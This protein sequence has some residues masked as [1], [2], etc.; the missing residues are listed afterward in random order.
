MGTVTPFET[1]AGR[2][3]RVR[4]RTP[5]RRQT[6]K[7]GFKTK[8]DAEFFLANVEV[9]K[10]SGSFVRPS[11]VAQ[12][13][14][15]LGQVSAVSSLRPAWTSDDSR[16]RSATVVLRALGVLAGILDVALKDGRIAKNVA[17][18]ADGSPRRPLR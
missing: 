9:S 18:G 4:Y 6:D 11:A 12:W 17:R 3:W 8:R 7:R 16:P 13:I 15:E 14:R 5:E 10:A 1:C 2:R